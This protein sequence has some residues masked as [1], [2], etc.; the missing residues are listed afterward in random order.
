[1]YTHVV[2]CLITHKCCRNLKVIKVTRS[3]PSSSTQIRNM[4]RLLSLL[5]LFIFSF[6]FSGPYFLQTFSFQLLGFVHNISISSSCQSHN[7]K[8][9]G[10]GLH[11]S[12]QRCEVTRRDLFVTLLPKSYCLLSKMSQNI[13]VRIQKQNR[14]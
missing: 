6:F 2:A 4:T 9:W 11:F 5:S 14:V 7:P 13:N 3:P 1:M 8:S 10:P 12:M